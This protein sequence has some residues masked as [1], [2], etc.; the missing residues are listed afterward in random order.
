MNRPEK[1]LIALIEKWREHAKWLQDRGAADQ[2]RRC[3]SELEAALLVG[4]QTPPD[5]ELLAALK[6]AHWY[7]GTIDMDTASDEDN[8][9]DML[10]ELETTIVKFDSAEAPASPVLPQ[11]EQDCKDHVADDWNPIDELRTIAPADDPG[12]CLVRAERWMPLPPTRGN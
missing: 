11:P 10:A 7:L 9:S 5:Q 3:A 8:Q 12:K 2:W 6:R 4:R 1:P